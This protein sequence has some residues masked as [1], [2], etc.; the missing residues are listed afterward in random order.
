MQSCAAIGSE[1]HLVAMQERSLVLVVD[2]DDICREAYTSVLKRSGFAT[3]DAAT[4]AEAVRLAQ[5]KRPR[6]V[7]LDLAMTPMNGFEVARILKRDPLTRA[8]KVVLISGF[9]GRLRRARASIEIRA[10]QFLEKPV[11]SMALLKVV[12][13]TLAAAS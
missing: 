9:A 12:E 2:D 5:E 13:E 8:C 7:L 11:S 10:E 1:L 6:L 3:I 4:G